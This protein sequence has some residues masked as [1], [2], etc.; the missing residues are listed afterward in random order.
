MKHIVLLGAALSTLVT[1]VQDAGWRVARTADSP[2]G[3][4]ADVGATGPEDAWVVRTGLPLLRWNG[5]TWRESGGTAVPYLVTAAGPGE[6]WQFVESP[7]RLDARHLHG[8]KWHEHPIPVQ[9]THAVAAL[10]TGPSDC[11]VSGLRLGTRGMEDAAWHWTG[12][13]W[14]EVRTPLPIT[15]FA[16]SSPADVWALSSLGAQ[17]AGH[18]A[19]ILRLTKA[20]WRQAPVP[21][22]SLPGRSR[23]GDAYAELHDIVALGPR[24]AYAVGGI[25]F[26]LGEERIVREALVLRWNGKAWLRL[27]HRPAET[28]YT[29]AVPDGAGG[30]WLATRRQDRS[31]VLTHYASG[32]WTQTAIGKDVTVTGLANVPGTRKMWATAETGEAGAARQLILTYP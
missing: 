27:P 15:D 5:K 8:G 13:G 9:G 2:S 19:A 10:A 7:A 6:A 29:E 1:G 22:I 20:G 11:W 12:K 16:A 30:L 32:R 25:S 21:S 24:E 3:G 17:S 4:Y 18:A 14:T 23:A 31:D 26:I 28:A